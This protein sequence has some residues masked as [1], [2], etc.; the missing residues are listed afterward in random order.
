MLELLNGAWLALDISPPQAVAAAAALL[1]GSTIA[2]LTGFGFAL[3]IVPVLLLIFAPPTVVVLTMGLAISSG[4]PILVQDR[5]L[6]RARLIAPLILP[7]LL[8]L[9][10]GVRML[11]RLN[12]EA[13]KLVAG[14]VVIT[15]ALIVARGLSIPG[16]RSRLAPLLAG[17]A[18]G[19]LGASVGMSGPP[20]VL[21][22]TD[23]APE[24]RVFRASMT[25]YFAATNGFVVALV[26]STGEVGG[27]ELW[28]YLALLPIAL[29]GRWIGQRLH[30][31]IDQPQ[32]RRITLGLLIVT[33][34]SAMATALADLL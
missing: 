31:Q 13:I 27:R 8:G 34:T 29:T 7:A 23:R 22:L 3:V 6:V 28:L 20:V 32:F 12:P 19:A 4:I 33:G 9:V 17:F 25:A 2:G 16:I 15:F 30:D 24:R 18:S 14:V 11:T 21:L 5:A 10:V 1:A 26:A